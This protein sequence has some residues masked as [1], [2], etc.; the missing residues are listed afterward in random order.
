MSDCTTSD[1]QKARGGN[2]L[3]MWCLF[4][5]GVLA[6]GACAICPQWM[7]ANSPSSN[8]VLISTGYAT[9]TTDASGGAAHTLVSTGG[10][11][12]EDASGHLVGTQHHRTRATPPIANFTLPFD[13]TPSVP[14]A[15]GLSPDTIRPSY[16][17][18]PP[19]A[20]A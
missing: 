7:P 14:P 5:T 18:P 16:E 11:N 20:N 12:V 3:L 8:A 19:K 17:P 1:A 6:F 10:G 4:A 15:S 2:G 9:Q 13:K